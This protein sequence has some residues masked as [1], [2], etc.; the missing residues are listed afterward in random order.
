ME[1]T[2]ECNIKNFKLSSLER[3]LDPLVL[4]D[5]KLEKLLYSTN[6]RH[7]HLSDI[8]EEVIITGNVGGESPVY[9]RLYNKENDNHSILLSQVSHLVSEINYIFNIDT[10]E[11]SIESIKLKTLSTPEGRVLESIVE[12]GCRLKA[13]PII[14]PVNNNIIIGFD[15]MTES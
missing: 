7:K 14:L 4:R 13:T 1:L 6:Q 3:I 15:V 12:A 9:G 2:L 5:L 8:L 11:I 10:E